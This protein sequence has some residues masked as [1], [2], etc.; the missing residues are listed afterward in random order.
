MN[1]PGNKIWTEPAA[2]SPQKMPL[3]RLS[4]PAALEVHLWYLHL[5]LLGGSLRHALGGEKASTSE[6]DRPVSLSPTQLRFSRRFYLRLLLGAY[7]GIPGKDVLLGRSRRGK[8]EL[9]M[10]RHGKILKFSTAKSEDRLLIGIGVSDLGVDLESASR[11]ASNAL[12]LA[13]RYFTPAEYV[14]LK[15]LAPDRLDEAFL[16]AWALN[17]AVV[18]ASGM[19]IANQL[20]RFTV[21]MNPDRAPVILDFDDECAAD[22]SL[23]LIRPCKN[24]IGAVASKQPRLDISCFQLLPAG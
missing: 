10:A 12:R 23:G 15:S 3:Q 2:F 5:G 21:E 8:P 18:K 22:W 11:K 4:M 16:R 19:G 13:Q 1:E 7:L 20:G 24:F 9:D 6:P 14:A 17:E